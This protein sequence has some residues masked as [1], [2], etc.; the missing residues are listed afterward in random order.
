MAG[1]GWTV[2]LLVAVGAVASASHAEPRTTLALDAGLQIAPN[3][4]SEGIS[5]YGPVVLFLGEAAVRV[6]YGVT[7]VAAWGFSA[8]NEDYNSR[9][10]SNPYLGVRRRFG[11]SWAIEIELGTTLPLL[12]LDVGSRCAEGVGEPP[13]SLVY[14]G[15]RDRNRGDT[16]SAMYRAALGRGYRDPWN[17]AIDW[18]NSV[19]QVRVLRE[20]ELG[21]L[22][23]GTYGVIAYDRNSADRIGVIG[24]TGELRP[25]C[26]GVGFTAAQ[27]FGDESMM[28]LAGTARWL[29][30]DG[31]TTFEVR[32]DVPVPDPEHTALSLGLAR[33]F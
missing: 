23:L 18:H 12:D 20:T 7:A 1:S 33:T 19:A 27:V 14:S 15:C 24:V 28:Q 25:R 29:R 9:G 5:G 6:V 31:P 13:Q 4:D 2:G 10:L 22:A 26:Y 11:S 8:A 17:W 3:H 32:L 16:E 21:R 30:H